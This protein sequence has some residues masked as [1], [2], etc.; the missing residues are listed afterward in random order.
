MVQLLILETEYSYLKTKQMPYKT[1]QTLPVPAM[2]VFS[3]LK[4]EDT[5][6]PSFLAFSTDSM[7]A[8]SRAGGTSSFILENSSVNVF[9]WWMSLKVHNY[10]LNLW[11]RQKE[12]HHYFWLFSKMKSWYK[13]FMNPNSILHHMYSIYPFGKNWL[14]QY[15]DICIQPTMQYDYIKIYNNVIWLYQNIKPWWIYKFI[16]K[17]FSIKY[18]HLPRAAL[19]AALA[20]RGST[21]EARKATVDMMGFPLCE[22]GT[23]W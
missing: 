16:L 21:T 3:R 18:I 2:P 22:N 14:K 13:C 23:G 4:P 5:S 11:T 6:L 19:A 7:W 20:T 8:F 17:A 9:K 15:S 12:N 10:Y 1:I